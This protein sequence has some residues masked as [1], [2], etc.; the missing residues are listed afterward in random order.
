MKYKDCN[1]GIEPE[2]SLRNRADVA[3][4]VSRYVGCIAEFI[5]ATDTSSSALLDAGCGE[6]YTMKYLHDTLYLQKF[7][8]LDLSTKILRKCKGVNPKSQ[9][10]AGNMYALPFPTNSFGMVICTEVLEHLKQP[11]NAIEE[12]R[13]VSSR[14]C[15]ISA[16]NEP[17][18]S[19]LNL[20]RLRHLRNLGSTPGHIQHWSKP[21]F[22]KLLSEHFGRVSIRSCLLAWN[23]A[24]CEKR[25]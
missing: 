19:I 12:I 9:L 7:I 24:L 2:D 18:F 8:G 3:F 22:S 13:R 23:I 4:A 15:I 6:G 20:V 14:Y 16:P 17:Y 11:E 5:R 21:M 25:E 1:Y 10:V